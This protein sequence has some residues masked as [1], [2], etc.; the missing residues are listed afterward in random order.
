M[1]Q[2]QGHSSLNRTTRCQTCSMANPGGTSAK[3]LGAIG[4]LVLIIV[5]VKSLGARPWGRDVVLPDRAGP[6]QPS[7]PTLA[8]GGGRS[9]FAAISAILLLAI[10]AAV[11]YWAFLLMPPDRALPDPTRSLTGQLDLAGITLDELE[12]NLF[13][14]GNDQWVV[15]LRGHADENL[16]NRWLSLTLEAPKI[17]LLPCELA[18]RTIPPA[19]RRDLAR[20][21]A[22][23]GTCQDGKPLAS[24][25]GNGLGTVYT[26]LQGSRLVSASQP[27]DLVVAGSEVRAVLVVGAAASDMGISENDS[28]LKVATPMIAVNSR[29]LSRQ[30]AITITLNTTRGADLEWTGLTPNEVTSDSVR[31]SFEGNLTSPVRNLARGHDPR[32]DVQDQRSLFLAG[33]L[34]GLA[35]GALLAALIEGATALRRA[36]GVG[37]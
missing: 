35:S 12:M 5:L 22:V 9:V 32:I 37:Y 25:Y 8:P 27:G 28:T 21:K 2:P 36:R 31:W 1:S 4:W 29:N 17:Q 20:R 16:P 19:H 11:G 7:T 24:T 10:T 14:L 13:A 30:S 6:H 15:V 26:R 3:P 18:E 33:A 23:I 34:A